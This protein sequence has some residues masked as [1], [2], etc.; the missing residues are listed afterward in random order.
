MQGA[1]R[2]ALMGVMCRQGSLGTCQLT[3]L[4]ASELKTRPCIGS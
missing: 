2:Q 4:Y 3:S 1:G